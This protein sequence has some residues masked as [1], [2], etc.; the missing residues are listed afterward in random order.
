MG[1]LRLLGIE[2]YLKKVKTYVDEKVG[3]IKTDW[4]AKDDENGFIY[5][6]PFGVVVSIHDQSPIPQSELEEYRFKPSEWEPFLYSMEDDEE[7]PTM[8][9]GFRK[10]STVSEVI[11]NV[12]RDNS[13]GNYRGM[14]RMKNTIPFVDHDKLTFEYMYDDATG[15]GY[16]V[17]KF[18][19]PIDEPHIP[20]YVND[21]EIYL[22]PEGDYLVSTIQEEFIPDTIAREKYV[23]EKV[24]SVKPSLDG[25][26]MTVLKYICNPYELDV[27]YDENDL[28]EDL[29]A[30]VWDE[31]RFK[32]VA[33][34]TICVR[35]AD[36][37]YPVSVVEYNRLVSNAGNLVYDGEKFTLE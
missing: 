32:P 15:K 1:L 27:A 37:V 26:N 35:D 13:G 5:N 34:F 16:M 33:C 29:K 28:P 24:A 11:H 19:S 6:K 22:V 7:N 31:D 20:D 21:Y 18:G 2:K 9:Y 30:V 14:Y 8:T 23:D 3:N 36:Y 17:A 25:V 4:L 10:E 12:Y